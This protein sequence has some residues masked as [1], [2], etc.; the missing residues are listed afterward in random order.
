MK[1]KTDK[2]NKFSY[3]NILWWLWLKNWPIV[4]ELALMNMIFLYLQNL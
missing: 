1:A 2:G 4:N 3:I